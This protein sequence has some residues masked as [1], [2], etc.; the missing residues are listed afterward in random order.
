MLNKKDLTVAVFRE[1]T[2]FFSRYQ[3]TPTA[4]DIEETIRLMD[5]NL[6]IPQNF[7]ATA[8]TYNQS[9]GKPRMEMVQMPPSRL[10]PQT[11]TLCNRLS[12]DDPMALLLG[13]K[14]RSVMSPK[15]TQPQSRLN[16]SELNVTLETSKM[17]NNPDEVRL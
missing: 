10:N 3:F 8:E 13:E 9:K 1:V 5:G 6:R 11:T 14:K 7:T 12:I 15:V 4:E 2:F 16:D 17:S